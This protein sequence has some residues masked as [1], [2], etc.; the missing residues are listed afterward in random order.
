MARQVP[1][2]PSSQLLSRPSDQILKTRTTSLQIWTN[3]DADGGQPRPRNWVQLASLFGAAGVRCHRLLHLRL[4]STQL[5]LAG[6]HH[7][8]LNLNVHGIHSSLPQEPL[9]P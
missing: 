8:V 3:A 7:A 5:H 9:L 2:L 4:L 1:K 6:S